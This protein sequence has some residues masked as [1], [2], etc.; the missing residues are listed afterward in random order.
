[1]NEKQMLHPATFLVYQMSTFLPR[2]NLFCQ[3]IK[4]LQK[5]FDNQIDERRDK[6]LCKTLFIKA[7]RLVINEKKLNEKQM[8]RGKGLTGGAFLVY[9]MS[10]F[11]CPEKKPA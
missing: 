5:Q 9:Q 6:C 10:N 1:M 8:L 7:S 3:L 4:L 2:K 11:L